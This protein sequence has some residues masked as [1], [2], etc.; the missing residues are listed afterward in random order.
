[1][2]QVS[3]GPNG[4]IIVTHD[5]GFVELFEPVGDEYGYWAQSKNG[6]VV[7]YI[8]PGW[9]GSSSSPYYDPSSIGMRQM[10]AADFAAIQQ[11]RRANGQYVPQSRT[12]ILFYA[13][14]FDAFPLPV[15]DASPAAFPVQ[16]DTF[17]V[18]YADTQPRVVPVTAIPQVQTFGTAVPIAPT[19]TAQPPTSA[20][21]PMGSPVAP[22]TLSQTTPLVVTTTPYGGPVVDGVASMSGAASAPVADVA[23]ASPGLPR[24]WPLAAAA[25]VL[26]LAGGDHA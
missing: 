12:D 10:S 6:K 7:G 18:P 4:S 5:N 3:S 23:A 16:G 11:A 20:A 25:A 17:T 21:T 9:L 2:R 15:K 24:W 26:A 13:E 19:T 22:A 1:M 8:L 14:D